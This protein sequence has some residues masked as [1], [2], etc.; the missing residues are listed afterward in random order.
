MASHIQCLFGMIVQRV[1][2]AHGSPSG[3]GAQLADA[4]PP[5]TLHIPSAHRREHQ[6]A[7]VRCG[8]S[9]QLG[10]EVAPPATP[11]I[12]RARPCSAAMTERAV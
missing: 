9:A 11:A 3:R 12:S 2:A 4:P 5:H 6:I 1:A 7:R 10:G 8:V